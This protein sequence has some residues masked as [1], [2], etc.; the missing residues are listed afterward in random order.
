MVD[1]ESMSEEKLQALQR[2]K[3]KKVNDLRAAGKYLEAKKL[4]EEVLEIARVRSIKQEERSQNYYRI[5]EE[6]NDASSAEIQAEAAAAIVEAEK[7][8]GG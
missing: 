3:N 2:T 6:A 5:A 8:I 7:L 4:R 1:L